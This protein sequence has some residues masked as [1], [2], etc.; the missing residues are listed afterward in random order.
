MPRPSKEKRVQRLPACSEF[1]SDTEQKKECRIEM[2]VEE[3]ETLR[4][5]DYMG[6]TQEECA[7]TMDVGRGTI[8]TLYGEARRKTARFLTEGGRLSICGGNFVVKKEDRKEERAMKVAVTYENGQIFQHFGKTE[9]FK[10]YQVEDGKIQSA[11]VIGT[12]GIGHGA[13]AGFLKEQGVDV[14][15][16]GGIGGGARNALAEARIQLYS[17]ACGDADAQVNSYLAG[18]LNYDPDFVCSHHSHEGGHSCGS[19]EGHGCGHNH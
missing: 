11:Q 9:Q 16:C 17:G 13:L 15:I 2:T 8:Q 5:I 3:F 4:L 6:M 14:L 18:T 19:H 12:N 1:Y 7:F 10:V